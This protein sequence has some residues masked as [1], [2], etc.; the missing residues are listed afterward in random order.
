[1]NLPS[2]GAFH[3]SRMGGPQFMGWDAG[4]YA[5]AALVNAQRANNHLLLMINRDPKKPKPKAPELFPTPAQDNKP[6]APKPG[7]FA[8]I[9]ASMMAAQR[10][11]RELLNVD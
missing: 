1:M 9:A 5:L 4:R 11:K 10:R 8:A 2:E 3:A 6:A 7:S